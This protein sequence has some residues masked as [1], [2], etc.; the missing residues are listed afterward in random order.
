M[1]AIGCRVFLAFI[2]FGSAL[3]AL[4]APAL[5]DVYDA[6]S[7]DFPRPPAL[8]AYIE[9]WKRIF[10]EFGVG[11]FVLH[12]RDNLGVIYGVV[13][14]NGA[15]NEVRAAEA[16]NPEIQRLRA[17]HEGILT[18]LADGIPPQDIGPEA[19]EVSQVW[20]CPCAPEQLRR[21]AS[22]LRVQ[23]GLR[24]RVDEGMQRA[25]R[26]LP[27]ILSTLRRYNVPH[28]LAALPLVESCFNPHAR[29]KA[30]A[31]GLW[32]FI[33]STGKRYHIITRH[34][35]DRRDPIRATEAAAHLRALDREA[36]HVVEHDLDRQV[37]R[38]FIG[39]DV[40]QPAYHPHTL[41]EF[42][43]HRAVGDKIRE[44]RQH[45]L[46]SRGPRKHPALARRSGPF[47]F[48]RAAMRAHIARDVTPRPAI[49]A[50]LKAQF[51][52]LAEFIK[53]L[54]PASPHGQRQP[55]LGLCLRSC[56]LEILTFHSSLF[57]L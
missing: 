4:T 44:W 42:D 43:H 48:E 5:A 12:D 20:G 41:F 21:A 2:L 9:F 54:R 56:H 31:V 36:R 6:T 50:A 11:D 46:M 17:R 1:R 57:T 35:D 10:T 25:R 39:P 15:T 19:V 7:P 45:R 3:F 47:P 40:H 34:R 27:Q 38:E 37:E 30:G 29:F 14:V 51:V 26:L 23:Q 52:L 8:S 13:R 53:F 24:E 49:G 28:E 55:V 32:Q 33:A 18:R 22:N 16:A